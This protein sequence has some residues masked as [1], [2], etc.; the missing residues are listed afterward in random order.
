ME[1]LKIVMACW[2]TVVL[3]AIIGSLALIVFRLE[4]WLAVF[5]KLNFTVGAVAIFLIF[6]PFYSKRM[7]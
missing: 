2:A 6:W 3:V 7:K 4:T 1:K 5:F